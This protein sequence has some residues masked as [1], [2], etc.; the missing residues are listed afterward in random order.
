MNWL[1]AGFAS[2]KLILAAVSL[3]A[4]PDSRQVSLPLTSCVP[5]GKS[6][7]LQNFS[8][9]ICKMQTAVVQFKT[10]IYSKH[11]EYNWPRGREE[12]CEAAPA[13]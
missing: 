6:F 4:G 9:L 12:G 7:P 1:S 13:I 8:V 11:L 2:R 3:E 5:L 10:N